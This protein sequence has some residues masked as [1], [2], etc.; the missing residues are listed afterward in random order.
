[1]S[2]AFFRSDV[3]LKYKTDKDKYTVGE[4]DITCRAAWCLKAFDVNEAGQVFAYV[5]YLRNLPYAEQLHWQSYNEAP[6]AGISERAITNDFEGAFTTFKDP[7]RQVVSIVRS[8]QDASVPWWTLRD[9]RLLERVSTPLT[10]SRDEWAEAF[11][12]L[13][14]LVVEGFV[15]TAIRARIEKSGIACEEKEQSIALLER[16]INQGVDL[17]E[18]QSLTGLRTVQLIRTKAKGHASG[19]EVDTLVLEVLTEHE[20]FT[21]HFKHVCATLATELQT[22]AG[23]FA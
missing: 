12:D 18:R 23:L 2:P 19:R 1:M 16:L 22:I 17:T 21:K 8:W 15:I 10:T 7:L 13:A 3:I 4:R 20:S 6:K 11:M 14:K 9:D 5:C